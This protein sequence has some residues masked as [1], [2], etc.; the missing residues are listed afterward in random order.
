[1]KRLK[2]VEY[3]FFLEK[4]EEIKV[5]KDFTCSL[6]EKMTM[7]PDYSCSSVF[8]SSKVSGIWSGP[9][10]Y[11]VAERVR[12][13][14]LSLLP[15]E[16]ADFVVEITGGFSIYRKEKKG[17]DLTKIQDGIIQAILEDKGK[18]V[19]EN[20]KY[21]VANKKEGQDDVV[22]CNPFETPLQINV[23]DLLKK[24]SNLEEINSWFQ[25]AYNLKNTTGPSTLIFQLGKD[26]ILFFQDPFL[27]LLNLFSPENLTFNYKNKGYGF[28]FP[29]VFWQAIIQNV[30]NTNSKREEIIKLS[31][32][33]GSPLMA[34]L[35]LLWLSLSVDQ[36]KAE[37]KRKGKETIDAWLRLIYLIQN[38]RVDDLYE[39]LEP[40]LER[41]PD[42][43]L[44]VLLFSSCFFD[45]LFEK[46]RYDL[47]QQ[48]FFIGKSIFCSHQFS[49]E[50]R[51]FEI[52]VFNPPEGDSVT[53]SN[54]KK[55][56][57]NTKKILFSNLKIE[58]VPNNEDSCVL[59]K[60]IDGFPFCAYVLSSEED[61][62]V[63]SKNVILTFM[64]QN[65]DLVL[66]DDSFIEYSKRLISEFQKNPEMFL[67][68]VE[69]EDFFH[70]LAYFESEFYVNQFKR[71]KN[72]E[73]GSE[74]G[75]YLREL[76]P[77]DQL[78]S[79]PDADNM[80]QELKKVKRLDDFDRFIIDS[81]QD[82]SR[83]VLTISDAPNY[84]ICRHCAFGRCFRFLNLKKPLEIIFEKFWPIFL[85]LLN[86]D[87]AYIEY[88]E[89]KE[90]KATSLL[91]QGWGEGGEVISGDRA[92]RLQGWLEKIVAFRKDIGKKI[93]PL[94]LFTYFFESPLGGSDS[95]EIEFFVLKILMFTLCTDFKLDLWLAPND[96]V[97]LR[98]YEDK[99]IL[100]N[101][102]IC[103][104]DVLSAVE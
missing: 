53:V 84:E 60:K 75:K 71:F 78:M 37:I 102:F 65:K 14:W 91:K 9:H 44:S 64:L 95:L 83:F 4:T 54:L 73:L 61:T 7:G 1:L 22:E 24:A 48:L 33:F 3:S 32:L 101:H 81:K 76:K 86:Q 16:P 77:D 42:Q 19:E 13:V 2:E 100:G 104:V 28:G 69:S 46:E 92:A 89:V 56:S 98:I 94:L 51:C 99:L 45:W 12:K 31:N 15:A 27:T 57:E 88:D 8:K 11:F 26:K 5:L 29:S 63:S 87:F 18:E 17:N 74:P 20:F 90:D 41:E 96:K 35:G 10:F 82:K 23:I 34:F 6:Y 36:E 39:C 72:L 103:N 52:L 38:N 47:S 68:L 59:V 93:T 79:L 70:K 50:N 40:T 21:F 97:E 25:M 55:L 66:T 49:F 58:V 43:D 85:K 80:K 62:K 67:E 30:Y